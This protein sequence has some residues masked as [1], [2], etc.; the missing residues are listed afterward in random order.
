[1]HTFIFFD[2]ELADGTITAQLP[3][4]AVTTEILQR[5]LE[6]QKNGISHKEVIQELRKET[7]PPGYMESRYTCKNTLIWPNT[8]FQ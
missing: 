8:K 4:P 5:I 1:M 7:V 3:N 6:M 2:T